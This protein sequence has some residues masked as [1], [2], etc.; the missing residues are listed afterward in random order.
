MYIKIPVKHASPGRLTVMSLALTAAMAMMASSEV[1][2]ACLVVNTNSM[3]NTGNTS[4]LSWSGAN[5]TLTNSG[6]LSTTGQAA[7]TSTG[8]TGTLTNSGTIQS[9]TFGIRNNG[10]MTALINNSSGVIAGATGISNNDTIVTFV[11]KGRISGT[12]S[13]ISNSGTIGTIDNDGGTIAGNITNAA[14]QILT[15]TGGTGSIFGTL[16]GS[17]NGIGAGN[18]GLITNT[19]SNLIF[20]SGNQLLN[21]NINVGSRT[22]INSGS[23]LQINNTINI[24]GNYTQNAAAI[25]NIGV[26]NG[27]IATGVVSA[28]SGYGRLI[29]SGVATFDAGTSIALKQVNSYAFAQ[30]QRFVV[31]QTDNGNAQYNASLLNYS[32]DGYSGSISGA[33]V[34]DSDNNAKT[35]LVITLGSTGSGATS[36]NIYATDSNAISTLSGLFR[37]GGTNA[38]MLNMFN[39]AAAIS[40]V[41]EANR[42]GAQLNPSANTTATQQSAQASTQAVLN[43]ASSHINTLRTAQASGRSGMSAGERASDIA[44]WGQA[45]G[46]Q[47]NQDDRA[48]ASG[49]RADYNGLLLGADTALNDQW[50]V[51]GVLSYAGT[52]VNSTGD[53]TGSS[54]HI[55]SYGLT[56]YGGYTAERWYLNLFGGVAQQQYKSLRNISYTGF[57]GNASGQ[58]DGMQYIA[59]AQAGYPIQLDTTTTLTPIAGLTYSRLS[60]D[61][62]TETGSAAALR[63]NAGSTSSVK[64][65]LGAKL[66]RSF[67]TSY[68]EITPSAQLSWRHEYRDTSV[69]SVANFAADTSGA[70]SFT[71]QGAAAKTNTGVL[72]FG[73]AV[74]RSRNLT[75]AARYTLEAASGYTAQTADVRL[76]YQF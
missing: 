52:S 43:I 55:K 35:D 60:Q 20:S 70:T 10:S 75:L 69:Q 28:D 1:Q 23:T 72:V 33:S 71:T 58:F 18:I 41:G 68:G 26:A 8:N 9:S 29:V 59:A 3:V 39:A 16:T 67:N 7:L 49:Y 51:G 14:S 2:A 47:A 22:V 19:A 57:N 32:A 5:L 64:S 66:E 61:A 74:A 44:V 36:P 31:V 34:T 30:G 12:V 27:A 15:F 53:N 38:D 45:F 50:R 46:G 62:Y 17:G 73:A 13:A 24:T 25:L 42:V 40:S 37:Y 76:R 6:V 54:S 48:G 63:V 56:A 65:D 11:N 21:D 4:C